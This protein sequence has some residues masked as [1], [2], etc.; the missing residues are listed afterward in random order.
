MRSTSCSQRRF[1]LRKWIIGIG[2][3]IGIAISLSSCGSSLTADQANAVK[4][5][6]QNVNGLGTQSYGQP[7]VIGQVAKDAEGN[8]ATFVY[9][10]ATDPSNKKPWSLVII[11]VENPKGQLI[12]ADASVPSQL[13]TVIGPAGH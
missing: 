12:F 13:V 11:I 5:V 6:E 3:V 8:T 2:V 10:P 4:A 9:V 7:Q 1:L